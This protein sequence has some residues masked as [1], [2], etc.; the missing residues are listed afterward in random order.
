MIGLSI[1]DGLR[2]LS[3]SRAV[4]QVRYYRGSLLSITQELVVIV[5]PLEAVLFERDVQ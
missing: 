2:A 3:A 1:T 5:V 4:L